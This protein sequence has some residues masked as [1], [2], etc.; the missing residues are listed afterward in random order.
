[1][2]LN[3]IIAFISTIGF[4]IMFNQPRKLLINSG[5]TGAI[6]F[7]TYKFIYKIS[8]DYIIACLLGSICVGVIGQVFA[9]F[10]KHPSTLFTIPGIIPLVPGYQL[11]NTML[12]LVQENMQKAVLYGT[13]AV[14]SS[15]S[16]AC[17][18]ALSTTIM[19]RLKPLLYKTFRNKKS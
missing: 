12:N 18:I 3:G 17:G 16:I 7:I 15:I 10:T 5:I 11:Y 8:G 14:F 6:G 13:Q 9:A 1:M 19:L 2:F 4:S